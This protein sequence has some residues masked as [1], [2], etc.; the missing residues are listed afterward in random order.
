MNAFHDDHHFRHINT[1]RISCLA[2]EVNMGNK[3]Q[4][5]SDTFAQTVTVNNLEPGH[6]YEFSFQAVNSA[7]QVGP[8]SAS[9]PVYLLP[10]APD[11]S[12]RHVGDAKVIISWGA[13]AVGHEDYYQISYEKVGGCITLFPCHMA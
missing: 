11:V 4:R 3:V 1:S 8:A 13:E 2:V 5:L 10:E 12:I 6:L 7:G 9:L